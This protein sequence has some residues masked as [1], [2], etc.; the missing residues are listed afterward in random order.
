MLGSRRRGR[1]QRRCRS[2]RRQAGAAVHRLP[3][4]GRRCGQHPAPG[5]HPPGVLQ[6]RHWA[7]RT[8][9][10]RPR[11][12]RRG[13]RRRADPSGRHRGWRPSRPWP[14]PR[15][16]RADRRPGR[17]QPAPGR[18]AGG[19]LADGDALDRPRA[20]RGDDVVRGLRS[21]QRPGRDPQR[22]DQSQRQVAVHL[23]AP[24]AGQPGPRP[25]R[26][27]GRRVR[28]P[29][30]HLH[31]LSLVRCA[32]HRAAV[33]LRPRPVLYHVQLRRSPADPAGGPGGGDLRHHQPRGADRRRGGAVLRR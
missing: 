5:R 18:G 29:R 28:V 19:R 1:R 27:P 2:D 24:S 25:R 17:G 3:P 16:G 11:G 22:S 15:P 26:L 6:R 9:R 30:R 7:Q 33:L 23:P 31:R 14:A 12:R 8:A 20:C 21:R 32:R 13:L 4:A 10:R